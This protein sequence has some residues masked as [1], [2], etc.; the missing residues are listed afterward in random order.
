MIEKDKVRL[1]KTRSR[2]HRT[3]MMQ[4]LY[5]GSKSSLGDRP[6]HESWATQ[7]RIWMKRLYWFAYAI[8]LL[9]IACFALFVVLTLL[10]PKVSIHASSE[11][12]D[13]KY[14]CVVMESKPRFFR[15]SPH[16][17]TFNI[18]EADSEEPLPGEPYLINNDSA[19]MNN[20]RME[21]AGG[22]LIVREL[23]YRGSLPNYHP[24]AVADFSEGRQEWQFA[25]L[26]PQDQAGNRP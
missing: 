6:G 14:R 4:S 21:W 22:K 16:I 26:I 9:I 19:S 25:D 15:A 5:N 20:F 7:F 2:S 13:G 8:C 12:P 11:S 23:S 1:L 17:Y 3:I 18:Y 10:P 24:T